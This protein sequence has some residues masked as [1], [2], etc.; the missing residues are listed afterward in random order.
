VALLKA[1]LKSEYFETIS[2]NDG[3]SALAAVVEHQPD[4]VVL[5][6]MMDGMDGFE[7]C[8]RIKSNP[9]TTHIPILILS[10]LDKPD[11]RAKALNAG[12]DAYITKPPKPLAF[13]ARVR[14]L[15]QSKR[16]IDELRFP[17]LP[18][19]EMRLEAEAEPGITMLN[20]DVSDGQLI[21][22]TDDR[23]TLDQIRIPLAPSHQVHLDSDP[24][25]ALLVLKRAEFDVMLVDVGLRIADG[26]RLS[27]RLSSLQ[28][29]R[30]TPLLL[31]MHD[32]NA[33]VRQR[34]LEFGVSDFVK[35]PVDTGELQAIVNAQVRKKR[36]SN[37]LRRRVQSSLDLA[38]RDPLTGIHNR[39]YLDTHLGPLVSQS[40]ARN[41]PLSLLLIDV[42]H[43][44]SVND[45]YGHDAGD[46]VLRALARRISSNTRDINLRCRFGGEEFVAVLPGTEP[47][48]AVLIGERLRRNV[49]GEP[50]AIGSEQEP[51]HVTVSVGV[52]TTSG[53]GD[54][55]EML[56]K[57][58]DQ[59]LYRAKK[60]GRNRVVAAANA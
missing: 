21:F 22:I 32:D 37:A 25:D 51:I 47:V 26:L 15:I 18:G 9:A 53:P 16:L 39:G 7:V 27:S 55:A 34:A 6:L 4:L 52:A 3:P 59:A 50:I 49:S 14:S 24:E 42:D 40:V 45:T 20:V 17:Q 43:F 31:V 23:R 19:S 56:I 1:H 54:T 48:L 35:L 12:A 2:A 11:D 41:R 10:G 29:T 30:R 33:I 57:R 8:S 60:E 36:Y 38:V 5:D 46:H 44:K 13:A 58:A 28:E